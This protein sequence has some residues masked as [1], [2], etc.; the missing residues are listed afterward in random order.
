MGENSRLTGVRK[1][2]DGKFAAAISHPVTKTLL[3][4]GTY[5]SPEVAACA[6]DLAARE[7]KGAK[8]KLN[9]PYPPPARLVKEVIAAPRHRSHGHDAPLFQVVT[10]P[11]DPTA[12]P[13]SPPRLVVY[14]P[15]SFEAPAGDSAP[16]PAYPF[17][18][19]PPSARAHLSLQ[20]AHVHVPVPEPQPPIRRMQIVTQ[21]ESCLS[22]SIEPIGASSSH[23]LVFKKPKLFVVPVTP[24]APTEGSGDNFTKPWYFPNS[25]AV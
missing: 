3:W 10:L 5:S 13:P 21:A 15:F 22:T 7:L 19:M 11:P 17:L 20:P 12:P 23:N 6:Y 18:Q 25:P 9:F 1:K 14:F 4:L 8:A 16:V 24:S 2:G